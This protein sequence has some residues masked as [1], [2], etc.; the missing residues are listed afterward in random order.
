MKFRF[1]NLSEE[2]RAE[3][4]F[5][6]LNVMLYVCVAVFL[7]YLT[8]H[9]ANLGIDSGRIGVLVSIGSIATIFIL[10]IWSRISDRTG[11][12]RAVLKIVTLGCCL[13]IL[14]FIFSN[15]FWALFFT[16]SLF[17]SFQVCLIPLSDAITIAYLAQTGTNF[18]RVRLG[19]TIGFGL[20]ILISGQVYA[21]SSNL[22]FI[23]GSL[24]LFVLFFFVCKIPQV[25]TEKKEK[26][27]FELKRVFRNKKIIFI[28]FIAFAV[29]IAQGFYFAFLGVY[30]QELGFSTREIGIAH[31][32]SILVEIP[33]FLFI[34][35][36]LKRFSV[37]AVTIF[38]GFMVTLRMLLLF[39]AADM[40][41]VYISMLGNGISFIGMYYSCATFIN[42]EMDDDLKSTG[43]SMLALCQM[44]LGNITGNLLGGYLSMTIGTR[45]TFLW[46]SIGLGAVCAVCALVYSAVVVQKRLRNRQDT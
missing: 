33:V 37:V 39:A 38:C 15:S 14:L 16:V 22:T 30:V 19:G 40:T 12:R 27:K 26:S 21:Y 4:L 35:R 23:L 31:F 32:M 18:S 3:V 46:F 42:K 41:F 11:N 8:A 6:S 43:Q 10:P 17:M 7:P 45:H 36:V 34:D 24:C 9:Y 5:F 20:M 44:G 2:K 25:E 13:S 1:G 29:Q 28:L